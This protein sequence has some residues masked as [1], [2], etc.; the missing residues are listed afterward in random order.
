MPFVMK[1]RQ[2]VARKKKRRAQCVRKIF[3]FSSHRPR[4]FGPRRLRMQEAGATR[5]LS[6]ESLIVA[7]PA[8]G[9]YDGPVFRRA[10]EPVRGEKL[11]WRPTAPNN[12]ARKICMKLDDGTEDRR[13]KRARVE[14][15]R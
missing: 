4:F 15:T 6:T 14:T 3:F 8:V 9:D 5:R 2:I 11:Y 7:Q 10:N 1:R 12:L 13:A